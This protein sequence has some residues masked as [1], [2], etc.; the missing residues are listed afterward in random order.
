M[1][2]FSTNSKS[3]NNLQIIKICK[4]AFKLTSKLDVEEHHRTERLSF[5]KKYLPLFKKHSGTYA[6]GDVT[7]KQLPTTRLLRKAYYNSQLRFV[8]RR[9]AQNCEPTSSK[10]GKN[11]K[12]GNMKRSITFGIVY[13]GKVFEHSVVRK[14]GTTW[15][16]PLC[17]QMVPVLRRKIDHAFPEMKEKTI[18]LL[19]D[20]DPCMKTKDS[21]QAFADSFFDVV[22][23]PAKSPDLN[24]LDYFVWNAAKYAYLDLIKTKVGDNDDPDALPF[25][26]SPEELLEMLSTSLKNIDEDDLKNAMKGIVGRLQKVIYEKGE[27]FEGKTYTKAQQRVMDN[28]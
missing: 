11:L 21:Q 19:L 1:K 20:N 23:G 27:R 4:K 25:V 12:I 9:P 22:W 5:A 26:L 7:Y 15:T 2:S 16:G 28:Y 3:D 18:L 17:Q 24:C 6:A 10:P 13:N 14:K 8:Y